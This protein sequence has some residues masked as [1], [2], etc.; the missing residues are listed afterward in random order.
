MDE[1]ALL[2]PKR[3]VNPCRKP[4]YIVRLELGAL[5][6]PFLGAGKA[7][8]K[9]RRW[10]ERA[11]V[12]RHGSVSVWHAARI[13]TATRSERSC[14]VIEKKLQSLKGMTPEQFLAYQDKLIRFSE[15]RDRAMK[16]LG[17][18]QKVAKR[19]PWETII[20]ATPEPEQPEQQ[21]SSNPTT[22]TAPDV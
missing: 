15:T 3:T 10:L 16:D 5:P 1:L 4:S 19:A 12:E 8:G 6:K 2:E 14:R 21:S 18:D 13:C 11:V 20:D 22:E 17:L 7:A 9:F